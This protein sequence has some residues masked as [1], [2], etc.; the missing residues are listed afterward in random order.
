MAPHFTPVPPRE[1]E[2]L[3]LLH[4][5]NLLDTPVEAEFDDLSRIASAVTGYPIALISLV[6][7]DRQWFK[8]HHGLAASE[9]PREFA[10]CAHAILK[11]DSTMEVTDARQ[12]PRFSTNPLV[13]G[14][15]HVIAY[16]GV[17]LLVGRE[18]QPIGTLCVIDQEPNKLSEPQ[19]EAL[20]ALA[21]QVERLIHARDE[22][23]RLQVTLGDLSDQ[24]LQRD[25]SEARLAAVLTASPA[26]IFITD[27]VGACG[28]TN[29]A[30]QQMAGIS[31][32]QA[33][34][35]GWVGAVHPDDRATV[36]EEWRV[37]CAQ[38]QPFT[39]RHR[40]LHADGKV[41]HARVRAVELREHEQHTG[42]LGTC[43]D[44]TAQLVAETA[45]RESEERWKFAIDGAGDGLW[46]WNAAT[47]SVFYSDTWK[48]QLG[49]APH[50]IGDTL[51][52]WDSR[53]H[54]DDREA[55]LAELQRHFLGETP[56]YSSAHRLL[57]KDGSWKWILDRGLVVER[58]ADGSPMRAVGTHTDLTSRRQAEAALRQS[59]ASLL[60]AQKL[61][62]IGDWHF[63][64]GG[65][66]IV[67][68][69]QVFE[70]FDRD[71]SLGAPDYPTFLAAIHP[72]DREGFTT[73]IQ[74]AL[75]HG[76]PYEIEHRIVLP[77][78]DIRW[79]LGRGRRLDNSEGK[80]IALAGTTQDVTNGVQAREALSAAR[81]AAEQATRA[82]ADFLATMSHEIRTPLNGVIGMTELLLGTELSTEQHD[83]AEA[84]HASGVSLL[85]LIND[86][87]DF[88]K[89]EAGKIDLEAVEFAPRQIAEDTLAMLA[90]RAQT[91]GIELYIETAADLPIELRGD[92]NRLRQIVLNLVGNAV[93]FTDRGEVSVLLGGAG[94]DPA[95]WNL[96][97]AVRDTGVGIAPE[98]QG[99]LF[100]AFTQ[101]HS[102]T[103]RQYGGTGLGLAIS[104]RLAGLMGGAIQLES[105]PGTGSTFTLAVG[106]PVVT[107][108]D[109]TRPLQGI[110]VLVADDHAGARAALAAVLT[111]AG[112]H[113]TT[114]ADV[115]S[116]ESTLRA[117]HFHAF[118]I[119]GG[120]NGMAG[121]AF[122][123][124]LQTRTD[125]RVPPV[126]LC[127][128]VAQRAG[129]PRGLAQ[130]VLVRPPRRRALLD[131]VLGCRNHPGVHAPS[132]QMPSAR[133]SQVPLR[134]L[135]VLVAED[136]HVNQMVVTAHLRRFGCTV[137]VVTDGN[138]AIVAC[139]AVQY[140]VVL[141]DCQMPELDGFGA[142]SAIRAAEGGARRV[143]IVALTANALEGDRERCLAAG[144]TDYLTKPIIGAELR[145]VLVAL[146]G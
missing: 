14:D 112:A 55:T 3:A 141:M 76:E 109:Q 140:D 40:F 28:Y 74:R 49:Y 70:N 117:R 108:P 110:A 54:P 106:L 84:A 36:A 115:E 99:R 24:I 103:A 4:S 130:D 71:P 56:Q 93:K 105:A 59:Q 6:D 31:D 132:R 18:R 15:P 100:T 13:I 122:L 88:S 101:A 41:V 82:K 39:S 111:G 134:P 43:E 51:S 97:I 37:A 118:V 35:F 124:Q 113:V 12:D 123:K 87:L 116:V 2:R 129:I 138:Q 46:D 83:Y 26:G 127:P 92:P 90:E 50:E 136:N 8:A 91:K 73:V 44:I 135:R 120:M 68:S 133:V 107:G 42:Y 63:D 143:P 86:I 121:C 11:P 22:K 48:S 77:S 65:Q 10:F 104:L 102:A 125:V 94:L 33:A 95:T 75:T 5:L 142:T 66:S 57:C 34:D 79:L 30:W 85:A 72:E 21:R 119:D 126:I 98:H 145:R 128:E 29:P 67:W 89:V 137:D 52:E 53:V 131:A 81:D 69:P 23:Q 139:A 19:R 64:L 25:R 20:E 78:G 45:L 16:A 58:Q 38:R 7:R 144:M 27:P 62:R 96:T 61:S 17:P 32:E 1:T 146:G 114:V 47:N 60:E 80:P 9:T